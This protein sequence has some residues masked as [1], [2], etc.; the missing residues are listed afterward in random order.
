LSNPLVKLAGFFLKPGRKEQLNQ[1]RI[2]DIKEGTEQWTVQLT[3]PNSLFQELK[4]LL[5]SIPPDPS[6][7]AQPDQKADAPKVEPIPN[8]ES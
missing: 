8:P 5:E 2:I 4:T 6:V 1:C 7:L 3:I